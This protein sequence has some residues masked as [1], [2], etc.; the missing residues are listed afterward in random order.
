M[1]NIQYKVTHS[2]LLVIA[3]GVRILPDCI[4][5]KQKNIYLLKLCKTIYTK[6]KYLLLLYWSRFSIYSRI[7]VTCWKIISIL[8]IKVVFCKWN[9]TETMFTELQL[10]VHDN[11]ITRGLYFSIYTWIIIISV[12]PQKFRKIVVNCNATK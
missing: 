3:V 5:K 12:I 9:V 11:E 1:F 4:S 7:S 6:H 8:Q 10:T 2:D